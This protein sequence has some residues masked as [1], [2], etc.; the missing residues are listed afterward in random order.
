MFF[1]IFFVI[2]VFL[3]SYYLLN[4]KTDQGLTW[5]YDIMEILEQNQ[6]ATVA[7]I[8]VYIYFEDTLLH[9][10]HQVT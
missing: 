8:K 5:S 1:L 2:T 3:F 10:V 6:M 4:T 9:H 7:T